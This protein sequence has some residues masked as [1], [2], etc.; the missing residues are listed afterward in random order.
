MTF[1]DTNKFGFDSYLATDGTCTE[2]TPTPPT[3]PADCLQTVG[4]GT[5]GAVYDPDTELVT[6]GR[7]A[8]VPDRAPIG[9]QESPPGDTGRGWWTYPTTVLQP[10]TAGVS[11]AV[12]SAYQVYE[13]GAM[14][15]SV[16]LGYGFGSNT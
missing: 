10:R 3:P 12:R 15:T 13:I 8:E 6:I 11:P 16:F 4:S 9:S 7:K 1:H 5:V 2:S 14:G